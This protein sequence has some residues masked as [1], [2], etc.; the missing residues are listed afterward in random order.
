MDI[1]SI[2]LRVTQTAGMFNQ[3]SFDKNDRKHLELR[4]GTQF[5]DHV[6]YVRAGDEGESCLNPAAMDA[7][8]RCHITPTSHQLPRPWLGASLVPL[9]SLMAVLS[10]SRFV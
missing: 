10:S 2:S 5:R 3:T 8:A 6:P 4:F 7:T 1:R 9:K